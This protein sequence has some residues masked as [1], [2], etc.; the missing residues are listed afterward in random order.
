MPTQPLFYLLKILTNILLQEQLLSAV[1]SLQILQISI[2]KYSTSNVFEIM[3]LLL[4]NF[5]LQEIYG[6]LILS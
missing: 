1:P 2:K 4:R 5:H 3:V 6:V